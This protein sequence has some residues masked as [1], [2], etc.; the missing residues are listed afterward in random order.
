MK[1][2]SLGGDW[3]VNAAATPQSTFREDGG[4]RNKVCIKDIGSGVYGGRS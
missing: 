4:Q 1:E 3:E 2:M